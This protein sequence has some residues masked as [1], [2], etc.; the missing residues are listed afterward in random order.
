MRYDGA[1]RGIFET[2]KFRSRVA[3]SLATGFLFA[4]LTFDRYDRWAT[5]AG[6]DSP[7]TSNQFIAVVDH[8]YEHIAAV[9]EEGTGAP[10]RNEASAGAWR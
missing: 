7:A 6:I 4:G 8:L 10:T 2:G 1:E 9:Q 3:L 5:A